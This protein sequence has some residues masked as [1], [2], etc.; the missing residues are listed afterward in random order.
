MFLNQNLKIN[1]ECF[2]FNEELF[3][4]IVYF[5]HD[6]YAKV[7]LILN[8]IY[9]I[10]LQKECV[11][12]HFGLILFNNLAYLEISWK[13]PCYSWQIRTA[14]LDSKTNIHLK[15][16]IL[17]SRIYFLLSWCTAI[18]LGTTYLADRKLFTTN[19]K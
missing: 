4:L 8:Y 17:K 15:K 7:T 2:Y 19:H 12:V 6:M 3:S 16:R 11:S 18:L 5:H 10:P 9:C 13:Q 1:Y 14:R